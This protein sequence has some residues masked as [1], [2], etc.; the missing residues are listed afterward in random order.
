MGIGAACAEEIAR[1]GASVVV[2]DIDELA[3]AQIVSTIESSGGKAVSVIADVGT[4]EGCRKAVEKSVATFGGLDILLNNVG[5]QPPASYTNIEDTSE[6]MWDRIMAVNLKSRFLMAKF[7][8]PEMRKRGGGVIIS[9]GSVQGQLSANLVPAY[10]ATK[11][12]DESLTRQM[13]LDYAPD[14]I[15]VLSVCPGGIDTPM[16]R[17]SVESKGLTLEQAFEKIDKTVPLGMGRGAD[18]AKVAVFLASEK[19]AFMTGTS[20]NVDGG[21]MAKGAWA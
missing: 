10:A 3:A 13:A 2:M 12:G 20:V 16:L 1:E 5:I 8:I 6:E 19:A 17:N 9:I 14:N 4:S 21:I 15:R 7:S 11:G 18:I